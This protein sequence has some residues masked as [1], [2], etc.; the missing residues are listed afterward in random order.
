MELPV[1]IHMTGSSKK[2]GADEAAVGAAATPQ[3]LKSDNTRTSMIRMCPLGWGNVAMA[4]PG[5]PSCCHH[6]SSQ[7]QYAEYTLPWRHGPAALG[8]PANHITRSD[9]SALR[10]SDSQILRPRSPCARPPSK[11]TS[12][13]PLHRTARSIPRRTARASPLAR[14]ARSP[15]SGR[16]AAELP[17]A[18]F[19][20]C[21]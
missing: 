12:P 19:G 21:P 14:P 6:H 20:G 8:N 17:R 13:R 15:P 5:R 7:I 18:P 10:L 11:Q 9:A 1:W 4:P 2:R 16:A 3:K